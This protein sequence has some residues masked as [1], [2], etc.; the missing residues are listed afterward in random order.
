MATR[1]INRSPLEDPRHLMRWLKAQAVGGSEAAAARAV[2]KEEHISI[3]AA[4]QSIRMVETYRRKN[5]KVEFD[6]AMRDLVISSIPQAKV[7]LHSLLSATEL[8]EVK[9]EKTGKVRV[10]KMQDKTTQLEAIRVLTGLMA[11][12]IPKA[13][14]VEQKI[15]QTTQVAAIQS[16]TETNEDRIRRIRSQAQQFN[17]LPPEVAAVPD[18]IDRGIEDEDEEEE[19]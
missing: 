11:A 18:R 12:Q 19:E 1:A 3:P 8:V 5:D 15:V 16:S 6:F 9:D 2:A 10:E 17:Q 14:V 7:T 4:R 13:P